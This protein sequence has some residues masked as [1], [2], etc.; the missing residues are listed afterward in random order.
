VFK[1]IKYGVP[2]KG[3]IPW[4]DQLTPPQMQQVASYIMTLKGTNPPNPKEPQG[5]VWVEEEGTESTEEEAPADS[6][7]VVEESEELAATAQ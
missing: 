2:A 4:E 7:V 3:M 1:T 5:E 6:T